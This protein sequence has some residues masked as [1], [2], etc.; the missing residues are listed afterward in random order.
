MSTKKTLIRVDKL[1]VLRSKMIAMPVKQKA[2]LNIR[3]AVKSLE[4]EIRSMLKNGY[5]VLDI[6]RMFGEVD[7]EVTAS[8]IAAYLREMPPGNNNRKKASRAGIKKVLA[9]RINAVKTVPVLGEAE[10]ST[11]SVEH[12]LNPRN[13]ILDADTIVPELTS[14]VIGDLEQ[15]ASWV[16]KIDELAGWGAAKSEIADLPDPILH[17]VAPQAGSSIPI[18]E[19]AGRES[20][21]WE[22]EPE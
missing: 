15:E 21:A 19:D 16:R 22:L 8:T 11:V 10:A 3:E 20:S 12:N 9:E 14:T 17:Q 5:T 7:A 18:D 13:P 2:E 4:V 6:A 1:E